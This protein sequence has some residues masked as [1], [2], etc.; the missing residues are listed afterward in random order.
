M[1][2]IAV[3]DDHKIYLDAIFDY[4]NTQ[5]SLNAVFKGAR[6]E[7]FLSYLM[8]G[9]NSKIDIL[10]LDLKL[11]GMSGLECLDILSSEYPSI[12]VIV[13]SMFKESPFIN[14]AIKKGAL[15]FVSKDIESEVL[16]RAIH[17]VFNEGYYVCEE[18]SEYLIENIEAVQ[19]ASKFLH[20]INRITKTELEVLQ[21][22]IQGLTANEI[23]QR[24]HKSPRTIEGHKQRLLDKTA[25]KNTVAL[26]T[27]AFREGIVM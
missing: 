25:M 22:I 1:I 13:V 16:L 21:Y 14:E 5:E 11:P 3:V 24:L 17:T 6:A 2:N 12:K 23:A 4:L 8:E 27:W 26:V 10:L 18:L 9:K 7:D 20:P 15:S 19:K